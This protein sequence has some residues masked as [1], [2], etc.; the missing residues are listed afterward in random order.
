MHNPFRADTAHNHGA[1]RFTQRIPAPF[2]E[3]GKGTKKDRQRAFLWYNTALEAGDKKAAY[4]VG[5]CYAYGIGTAFNYKKA[6]QY[7]TAA[8]DAGYSTAKREIDRLTANRN[9]RLSEKSFSTAMGLLYRRK[10]NVAKS[11]LD[12]CISLGNPKAIYTL[13]CLHEFGV[14]VPV[15]KDYA[16]SLYEEAYKLKFRD[17]R[18]VYKLRVLKMVR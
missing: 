17:P 4:E 12:Q 1:F 2:Y 13:G 7:L 14:G 3:V 5:R 9:S 18:A 6:M 15:N 8:L 10:F 16:F 11:Y